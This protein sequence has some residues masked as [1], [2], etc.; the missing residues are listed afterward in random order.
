LART[1]RPKRTY[2]GDG[3]MSVAAKNPNGSGSVYYEPPSLR[4]DGREKA[5]RWRATYT[6]RDGKTRRVTAATRSEV[7]ARR[8]ERIRELDTPS[9]LS[10]KFDANTTVTELLEW[11]LET[12]ARH[13]VKV[14]TLDSYRRFASY[15][16]DGIGSERIADV[17]AEGL[18]AWQSELLDKYAPYTV[19][20]CRKVC[21]QAFLEA[22]KLGLIAGNPFDLVKA[23]RAKRQTAGRALSPAAAKALISAA[24][25]LRYGAAITLLFCQGWRVSEVLGL[26]WGDLDLDAGTARIRRGAAYTKST[27]TALG[28]TKTSGAEGVHFLAPISVARLRRHLDDQ[29]AERERSSTPWP[30]HVYDGEELSMVFTTQA[31]GLV[32]RQAVVTDIGRAAKK[33]KLDPVGIATHTGRRTVITALYA[34]GNLDLGDVARHV[35]HSDTKTTAGYVRDLGQRPADTARAAARLLDPTFGNS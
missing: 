11:W 4:P 8:D 16:T 9:Q 19:L 6:D 7:E 10:S 2:L 29:T 5:G 30:A 22:M 23:P 1:P 17:S 20:N 32:N 24:Q 31:G 26:A 15:L 33:A 25:D 14:S 21:R 35:G 34:N 27:G 13:Q 28:P 12:V 3:S 18:T